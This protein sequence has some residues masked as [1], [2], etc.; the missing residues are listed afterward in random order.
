MGAAAPG[1]RTSEIVRA[2]TGTAL[3]RGRRPS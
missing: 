1:K 2:L 3:W